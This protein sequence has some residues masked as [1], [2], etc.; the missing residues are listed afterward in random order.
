LM[1]RPGWESSLEGWD[2]AKSMLDYA[3]RALLG[4]KA[5]LQLTL[6]EDKDGERFGAF[7]SEAEVLVVA[8]D[9]GGLNPLLGEISPRVVSRIC[10]LIVAACCR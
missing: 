9:C 3:S 4:D 8:G 10:A 1:H 2:T 5:G 7:P 6:P